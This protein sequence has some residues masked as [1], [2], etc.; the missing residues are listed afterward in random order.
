MAFTVRLTLPPLFSARDLR[1]S[2][3]DR[4]NRLSALLGDAWNGSLKESL[5][6]A[7]RAVSEQLRVGGVILA[8]ECLARA[9]SDA[10]RLTFAQLLVRMIELAPLTD[11]RM[12]LLVAALTDEARQRKVRRVDLTA[13]SA[14]CVIEEVRTAV[15][16]LVDDASIRVQAVR[17]AH[18]LLRIPDL[19]GLLVVTL[20][21]QFLQDWEEYLDLFGPMVKGITFDDREPDV[22]TGPS[23]ITRAL[24][25]HP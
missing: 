21:T 11:T 1:E 4:R 14:I 10:E 25:G 15:T 19:S 23:S 6:T 7:D 22:V 2:S 5:L 24:T 9:G 12:G 16:D 18:A 8:A 3:T 17:Q 20:S 13:G